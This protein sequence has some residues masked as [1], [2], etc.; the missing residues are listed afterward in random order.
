MIDQAKIGIG[1][2]DTLINLEARRWTE[3][4]NKR[5]TN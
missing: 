2:W 5:M 3:S 4:K 1:D